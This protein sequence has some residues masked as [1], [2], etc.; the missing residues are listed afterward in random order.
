VVQD[1]RLKIAFIWL[2]LE[3][4]QVTSRSETDIQIEKVH[5]TPID[6]QIYDKM[7]KNYF[8]PYKNQ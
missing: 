1:Q 6:L 7:Q 5:M 8:D 3:I 4:S 2:I